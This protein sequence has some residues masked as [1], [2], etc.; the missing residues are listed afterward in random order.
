MIEKKD[1]KAQIKSP[2]EIP[3]QDTDLSFSRSSGPGGQNVNKRSTKATVR[4]HIGAA[5]CITEAE[6]E[7][8]R[9]WILSHRPSL[10]VQAEDS[11][12]VSDQSTRTQ[13]ANRQ[14]AMIKLT[15]LVNQA[16]KPTK[17]RLP[18][19]PPPHAEEKRLRAKQ[20]RSRLKA[21]RSDQDDS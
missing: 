3:A 16:L 10:F 21:S 13:D 7:I 8:V 4:F 19:T 14:R 5:T 15:T 9:S 11:I 18:T 12:L 20:I 17:E 2:V 6:K 1:V